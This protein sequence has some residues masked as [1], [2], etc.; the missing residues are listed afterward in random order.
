MRDTKI[1][2]TKPNNMRIIRKLQTKENSTQKLRTLLER[3][4]QHPKGL[5]WFSNDE[6]IQ[7]FGVK[8]IY[9]CVIKLESTIYIFIIFRVPKWHKSIIK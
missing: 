4:I 8:V 6:E 5:Y 9:R 3:N 1:P 7:A 2:P